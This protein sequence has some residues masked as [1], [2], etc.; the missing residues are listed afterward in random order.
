MQDRQM[1]K[2]ILLLIIGIFCLKI[3]LADTISVP[4]VATT[5]ESGNSQLNGVNISVNQTFSIN[6]ITLMTG[7][8][9]GRAAIINSSNIWISQSTNKSGST[10]YFNGSPTLQKG[11]YYIGFDNS[12]S[13]KNSALDNTRNSLPY[14]FNQ[15]N[16]TN[17]VYYSG[18]KWTEVATRGSY[19]L[20]YMSIT[21]TTPAETAPT[22]VTLQI[23]FSNGSAYPND[24]FKVNVSGSGQTYN[25]T[26]YVYINGTERGRVLVNN[27]S[28]FELTLARIP[29]QY[30]YAGINGTYAVAN[31]SAGAFTGSIYDHYNFNAT[32]NNVGGGTV[33]NTKACSFAANSIALSS[34]GACV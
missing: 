32:S 9:V 21:N 28:P 31:N 5:T 29:Q 19:D 7:S 4:F 8:T 12:G 24:I 11:F 6:S 10:F 2:I 27:T 17:A 16:Y 26:I 33:S 14:K 25:I 15:M 20:A 34:I 22:S 1:K 23:P 18:G 3:A 30:W 13:N